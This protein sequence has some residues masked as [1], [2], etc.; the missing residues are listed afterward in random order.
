MVCLLV[1]DTVVFFNQRKA[2]FWTGSYNNGLSLSLLLSDT[3]LLANRKMDWA[4]SQGHKA[5][6]NKLSY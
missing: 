6:S 4:L 5:S 1:C 3:L 2:K